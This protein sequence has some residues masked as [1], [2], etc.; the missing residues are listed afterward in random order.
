MAPKGKAGSSTSRNTQKGKSTSKPKIGL[1]LVTESPARPL[2]SFT[3]FEKSPQSKLDFK[4]SNDNAEASGSI[5]R[6]AIKDASS[7][8]KESR[9]KRDQSI[10]DDQ[11][12][13][14]RY[15]PRS[16]AELA[17]HKK[18]IEQVEGWLREALD[19]S[20]KIRKY[21]RLLVLSGPAGS[22]KSALVRTLSTSEEMNYEILEWRSDGRQNLQGLSSWDNGRAYAGLE[23]PGDAGPS[24]ENRFSAFLSQSSRFSTLTIGQEDSQDDMHSTSTPSKRIDRR[25]ILIDDLPNLQYEPARLEFQAAL[26]KYICS[27][28]R[29]DSAPVIL[30]LSDTVPRLDD[31]ATSSTMQGWKERN[32]ESLNVRNVISDPVRTSPAFMHISFNSVAITFLRKALLAIISTEKQRSLPGAPAPTSV[33]AKELV[34]VV[35]SMS[36]GDIRNAINSL[37]I[38]LTSSSSGPTAKGSK[39]TADGKPKDG[40]SIARKQ[41]KMI[42]LATGREA[43]LAI[44]HALGKILYNKRIGDPQDEARE[45]SDSDEEDE[46]DG[47]ESA[48]LKSAMN[49]FLGGPI[50]Q[51]AL[52]LP[53]HLKQLER[54][55]SRVDVEKLWRTMP[56]DAKTLQIFLH[57]NYTPFCGYIEQCTAFVDNL[58]YSD[59][60]KPQHEEW[61]H[62][63]LSQYYSFL[64]ATHGSLM[65]LPSPIQRNSQQRF[66]GV[67][68]FETNRKL[69]KTQE[70]LHDIKAALH[71]EMISEAQNNVSPTLAEVG[72]DQLAY[73]VLPL[74][75]KFRELPE[76]LSDSIRF[77]NLEIG[78]PFSMNT[79]S[80]STTAYQ[81]GMDIDE[82]EV[83][84]ALADE[85]DVFP[86]GNPL[87]DEQGR[88]RQVELLPE[89]TPTVA[90]SNS[91]KL[92]S[93]IPSRRSGI[94]AKMEDIRDS[95]EDEIQDFE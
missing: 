21:R 73:E 6:D 59:V 9:P 80:A 23:S 30:I 63:S 41:A 10:Q 36:N 91:R 79:S 39:R 45:E 81:G 46:R 32:D 14:D 44:F 76:E 25:I 62:S 64:V 61:F 87:Y 90:S 1:A 35:A 60:L 94:A 43:S 92:P 78:R 8:Q 29:E 83:D 19:G 72:F 7:R 33:A 68:F 54:R 51:S 84:T 69:R 31:W 71:E 74:V 18:K 53:A 38:A 26:E 40:K 16:K 34:D 48:W 5:G 82:D 95:D 88:R 42:S 58:S 20:Q 37:Q 89:S 27:P 12:W 65:S 77:N 11:M 13:I 67:A 49:T 93:L 2:T 70:T 75:A 24:Q 50:E 52:P 4:A 57:Q 28:H 55:Q 66:R 22:G 85:E 3:G 56:M 47:T 15:T 17:V 86:T